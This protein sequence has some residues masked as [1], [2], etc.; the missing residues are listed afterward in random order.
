MS[1]EYQEI[2]EIARGGRED[3]E[4]R[5]EIR[6]AVTA[7]RGQ[8]SRN[9]GQKRCVLESVSVYCVSADRYHC[10]IASAIHIVD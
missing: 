1:L 4:G 8:G 3:V 10:F 7:T 9:S 2:G 6:D 5:K